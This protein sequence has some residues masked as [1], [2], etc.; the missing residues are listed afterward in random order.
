V[1]KI[2]LPYLMNKINDYISNLNEVQ[3]ES[4]SWKRKLFQKFFIFMFKTFDFMLKISEFGNY[5]IFLIKG[6]FPTIWNRIFS[7]EYVKH[8]KYIT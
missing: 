2:V 4:N 5:V 7:L 3:S 1:C 6:K 8:K